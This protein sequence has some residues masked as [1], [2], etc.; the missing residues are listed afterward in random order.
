MTRGNKG[1]KSVIRQ[2]KKA[3]VTRAFRGI[4]PGVRIGAALRLNTPMKTNAE[5]QIGG[6]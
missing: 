2:P 5:V 3:V 6:R 1:I 4:G